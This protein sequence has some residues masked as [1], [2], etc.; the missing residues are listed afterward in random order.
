MDRRTSRSAWKA[1]LEL[2]ISRD[3]EPGDMDK[4]VDKENSTCPNADTSQNVGGV[5]PPEHENGP[6]DADDD[7]CS[8]DRAR[9]AVAASG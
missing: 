8:S 9:V 3:E 6:A 5:V 2:H 4:G 1:L 7:E